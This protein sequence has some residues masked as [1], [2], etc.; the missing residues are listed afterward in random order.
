MHIKLMV[1]VCVFFLSSCSAVKISEPKR[2]VLTGASPT[3]WAKKRS[4]HTVFVSA[5]TS[6]SGYES[7]EMIYIK[8]PFQLNAFVNHEWIAP[9]AKMLRSVIVSSLQNTGA[10]R[11]VVRTFPMSN[12]KYKVNVSV[13]TLEHNFMKTPSQ[14][15]LTLK[16]DVI[17]VANSKMLATKRFSE[18]RNASSDTPYGGVIAANQATQLLMKRLSAFIVK[19]T[20]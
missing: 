12:A 1:I 6:S 2:Y 14:V 9:P 10:F 16:V 7:R 3:Q 4:S 13:L 11:A 20:R 5:L 15:N 19:V 18:S 17:D 8:T